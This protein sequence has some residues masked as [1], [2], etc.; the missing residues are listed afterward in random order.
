VNRV[1]DLSKVLCYVAENVAAVHHVLL[2]FLFVVVIIGSGFLFLGK[3]AD[4]GRGDK[5]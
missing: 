3:A 2:L 4:G 1:P 5:I